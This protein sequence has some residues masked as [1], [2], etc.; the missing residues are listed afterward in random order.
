MEKEDGI[1]KVPDFTDLNNR[2]NSLE[3]I[4]LLVKLDIIHMQD[5]TAAIETRVSVLEEHLKLLEEM[6]L[7][8]TTSIKQKIDDTQIEGEISA[9]NINKIVDGQKNNF[10]Q[11]QK[12]EIQDQLDEL[13]KQICT[14]TDKKNQQKDKLIDKKIKEELIDFE[15]DRIELNEMAENTHILKKQLK[16]QAKEFE[17]LKEENKLKSKQITYMQNKF[18]NLKT[19]VI[20]NLKKDKKQHDL[21]VS[22]DEPAKEEN[23]ILDDKKYMTAIEEN[24]AVINEKPMEEEKSKNKDLSFIKHGF[25]DLKSFVF[26]H[27]KKE[28]EAKHELDTSTNESYIKKIDALKD[29]QSYENEEIDS[30]SINANND[31]LEKK[32]PLEKIKID[33]SFVAEKVDEPEEKERVLPDIIPSPSLD[34]KDKNSISGGKKQ[35]VVNKINKPK[36]DIEEKINMPNDKKISGNANKKT[37]TLEKIK[38]DK[39][40]VAEKVD[41]PEE[42]EH[43][44]IIKDNKSMDIDKKDEWDE[45]EEI[46]KDH[47]FDEKIKEVNK[48]LE[49]LKQIKTAH[50]LEK[51]P[52]PVTTETLHQ[53]KTPLKKDIKDES[54][55]KTSATFSKFEKKAKQI[56]GANSSA[57]NEKKKETYKKKID[58]PDP[59]ENDNLLD[60]LKKF[61]KELEKNENS[62]KK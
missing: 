54:T 15:R 24:K 23:T 40:F 36:E 14:L 16:K 3:D 1:R 10:N 28:K 44:I 30:F 27:T 32:E 18:E 51:E 37:D 38:I 39:S 9:K 12:N 11:S 49:L 45:E 56:M 22:L 33:K 53:K 21:D 20:E 25:E 8:A 58:E 35:V 31:V 29:E 7:C 57:L 62:D 41:E 47:L 55:K 60:E 46:E 19:F 61:E 50:S 42:K 34:N 26:E 52:L 48:N 59:L 4:N 6:T 43:M 13:K 17:K 5:T 2:I